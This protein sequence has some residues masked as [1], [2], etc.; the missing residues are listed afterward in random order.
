MAPW[1][2][3]FDYTTN[4]HEITVYY[5]PLGLGNSGDIFTLLCTAWIFL[6]QYPGKDPLPMD[7]IKMCGGVPQFWWES[8]ARPICWGGT[9]LKPSFTPAVPGPRGGWVSMQMTG[10]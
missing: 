10:A 2:N 5:T 9:E 7:H 3:S 6:R 1:G 8:K 4:R